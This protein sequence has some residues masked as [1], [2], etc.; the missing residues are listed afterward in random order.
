[1]PY[2]AA[3]TLLRRRVS[4]LDA[5]DTAALSFSVEPSESSAAFDADTATGRVGVTPTGRLWRYY[6]GAWNPGVVGFYTYADFTDGED[7]K[8]V[9]LP[10]TPPATAVV[11][12]SEQ[13][14]VGDPH[15]RGA[16]YILTGNSLELHLNQSPGGGAGANVVRIHAFV[17]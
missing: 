11:L 9:T 13:N 4:L 14:I 8:T 16:H 1:M 5:A 10:F 12:L 17:I 3:N 6:Q 7:E 2:S 15:G